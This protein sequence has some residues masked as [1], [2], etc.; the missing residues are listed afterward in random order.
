MAARPHTVHPKLASSPMGSPTPCSARAPRQPGPASGPS[1]LPQKAGQM[2]PLRQVFGIWAAGHSGSG[3]GLA[4]RPCQPERPWLEPTLTAGLQTRL[5][6]PYSPLKWDWLCLRLGVLRGPLVPPGVSPDCSLQG[7][8]APKGP[9]AAYRSSP[10][11]PSPSSIGGTGGRWGRPGGSRV[12]G[13][14]CGSGIACKVEDGGAWA[15]WESSHRLTRP[16]KTGAFLAEPVM[17]RLEQN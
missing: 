10:P 17:G 3:Q 13:D 6:G 9:R 15:L 8:G 16:P 1:G 7:P 5:S 11:P 14:P 2:G 12:S 4:S